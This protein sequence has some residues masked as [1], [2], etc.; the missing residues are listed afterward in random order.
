MAEQQYML[1]VLFLS[2]ARFTMREQP[3]RG[4][5]NASLIEDDLFNDCE[6]I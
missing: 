2:H 6:M 1:N 4:S 5:I 3:P